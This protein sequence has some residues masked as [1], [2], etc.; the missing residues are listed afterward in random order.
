[1]KTK[2]YQKTLKMVS[3][4]ISRLAHREAR[5]VNQFM[6]TQIIFKLRLF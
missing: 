4:A 2:I 6:A 3:I 5:Y 1:M